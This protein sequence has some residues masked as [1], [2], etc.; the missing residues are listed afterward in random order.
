MQARA[1]FS[2]RSTMAWAAARTAVLLAVA[3][4]VAITPGDDG[5]QGVDTDARAPGAFAAGLGAQQR[6]LPQVQRNC[7]LADGDLE[8]VG[9]GQQGLAGSGTVV[10]DDN[11]VQAVS[12]HGYRRVPEDSSRLLLD[13][14]EVD[15]LLSALVRAKLSGQFAEAD[16]VKEELAGHGIAVHDHYKRWRADGRPFAPSRSKYSG[17]DP[18]GLDDNAL[19]E[20]ERLIGQRFR[21]KRLKRYAEADHSREQL[22]ELYGVDV[23]DKDRTWYLLGEGGH[24][25]KQVGPAMDGLD[26]SQINHLLRQRIRAKRNRDFAVSDRIQDELRQ[27]GVDLDDRNREWC[28]RF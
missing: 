21:A 1:D 26:V 16:T 18:H 2:R 13:E 19:R 3:L 28:A 10:H 25:Y 22:Q 27:M 7:G 9:H 15:A 23:N 20:V 4:R 17:D 5:R 6:K 24:G 14:E 12:E 11:K 8:E